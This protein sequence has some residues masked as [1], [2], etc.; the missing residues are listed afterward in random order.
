[1]LAAKRSAGVALQVDLRN[2][3]CAGDKVRESILALKPGRTSSEVQ[4]MGINGRT[5]RTDLLQ[6]I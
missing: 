5:K 3:L 4:T 2:M 6:K 1:M